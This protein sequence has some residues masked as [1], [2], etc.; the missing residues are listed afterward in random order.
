M[1]VRTA[2]RDRRRNQA[3]TQTLVT[4]VTADDVPAASENRAVIAEWIAAWTPK[5]IEAAAALSVVYDRIP[6]TSES[7]DEIL[8][9]AV[10]AQAELVGAVK[11][12]GA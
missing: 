6:H 2:E 3:W 8:D 12:A 1:I 11:G 10:A 7:F 9:G 4:L 5:A